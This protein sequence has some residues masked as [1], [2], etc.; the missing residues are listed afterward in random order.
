MRH[1][2]VQAADVVLSGEVQWSRASGLSACRWEP[3][4]ILNEPHF[5]AADARSLL[6]GKKATLP[7]C[8]ACA[9]LLDL[10]LELRESTP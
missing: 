9:A 8:P 7:D 4:S 6:D 3:I 1:A 2:T 5:I 10:A